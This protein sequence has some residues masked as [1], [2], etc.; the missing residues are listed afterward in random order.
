MDPVFIYF[1]ELNFE[2]QEKFTLR[3]SQGEETRKAFFQKKDYFIISLTY[4]I[5]L[6]I[7]KRESYKKVDK[8]SEICRTILSNDVDTRFNL[9]KV[10]FITDKG[11]FSNDEWEIEINRKKE[12]ILYRE[13]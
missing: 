8:L 12:Q 7:A 10:T 11:R 1:G 2:D 6:D 9:E 13:I 4:F 5:K 3:F